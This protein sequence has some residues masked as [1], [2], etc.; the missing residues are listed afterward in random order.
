MN[1]DFL[2][3]NAKP[4]LKHYSIDGCALKIYKTYSYI[5]SKAIGN[6]QQ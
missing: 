5:Q 2:F 3:E 4:L 1:S 6:M